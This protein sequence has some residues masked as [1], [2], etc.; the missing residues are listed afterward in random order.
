[1]RPTYAQVQLA[2]PPGWRRIPPVTKILLIASGICYLTGLISPPVLAFLAADTALILKSF[3]YWRLITHPFAIIGVL[4]LIFGLLLLWSFGPEL[5]PEW[6]S[7]KFAAFTVTAS[8]ISALLGTLA[9]LLPWFAPT[10]GYGLSGLLTA[11]IV[12]WTLRGPSL[13]VYF[14]GAFPMTRKVFAL[15][16]LAI[17]VFSEI[18]ATRSVPRLLFVLGGIP[19]AWLFTK[20]PRFFTR[21]PFRKR[22]FQVI[23]NDGSRYTYH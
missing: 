6:G 14:F 10:L 20:P 3:Q 17:V 21:S 11:M 22:R 12:A 5:E 1:M 8:A 16:A 2:G 19:V 7:R 23:R 18:E 13:P 15:I 4:N 9:T